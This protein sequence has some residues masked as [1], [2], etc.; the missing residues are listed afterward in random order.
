MGVRGARICGS[1]AVLIDIRAD[2]Q[3][4]ERAVVLPIGVPAVGSICISGPVNKRI[5]NRSSWGYRCTGRIVRRGCPGRECCAED[6]PG[7]HPPDR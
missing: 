3:V 6:L 2:S 5:V 4:A 1:G 7:E